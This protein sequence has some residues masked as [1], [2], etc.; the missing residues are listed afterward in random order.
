LLHQHLQ[1]VKL[2]VAGCN[3]TKQWQLVSK[4]ELDQSQSKGYTV[5][6]LQ[7]LFA[8]I[9]PFEFGDAGFLGNF[10]Q[11]AP[12]FIMLRLETEGVALAVGHG[13]VVVRLRG[14]VRQGRIRG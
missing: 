9:L 12:G 10:S 3:I 11:L 2:G 5:N 4:V 6:G 13:G 7:Q 1:L 8:L 14:V